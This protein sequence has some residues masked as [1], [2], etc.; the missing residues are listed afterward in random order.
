[1]IKG[2]M[3]VVDD[4]DALAHAAAERIVVRLSQ[5]KGRRAVVLTGGRTPETLYR[6]LGTEA[7]RA[8][9]PWKETHW[10]WGDERFVAND[11]PRNNARMAI[12]AFLADVPVPAPNIHRMCTDV[13]G[14]SESARLY[15]DML[16][17]FHGGRSLDEPLFDFVLMGMGPDGHTASLYPGDRALD[18]RERWVLPI[19]QAKWEPFVPRVTL[20]FPAMAS[21]REM[22]FV[23]GGAD[24][25][26]AL[27]RIERGEPLPAARAASQG[28]LGWIIERDAKN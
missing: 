19:A 25:R 23:V 27:A 3:Q 13:P 10:F 1:V 18:E 11:D 16:R 9:I 5:G 2:W 21:S 4:T 12:Q 24:K 17:D 7:Y 14:P 20:T 22:L 8:R 15:E 26:D 28:E 6:L